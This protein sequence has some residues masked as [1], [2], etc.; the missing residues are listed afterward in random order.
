MQPDI[1]EVSQLLPP[2]E[3]KMSLSQGQLAT[4]SIKVFYQSNTGL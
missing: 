1:A 4:D 2:V 3:V